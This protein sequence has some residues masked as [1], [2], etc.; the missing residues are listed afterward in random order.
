[1]TAQTA[2]T[3]RDCV[4]PRFKHRHGTYL[5]YEQDHC[6][7]LPCAL[8]WSQAKARARDGGRYALTAGLVDKT[9]TDRRIQGLLAIGWRH[10]DISERLARHLGRRAYSDLILKHPGRSVFAAT[11]AAVAAVY[12]ELSMTLGPSQRNRNRA[13]KAGY[14]PPLSWDDDQLDDPA[15]A[16]HTPTTGARDYLPCGTEAAA[17]RHQRRGEPLDAACRAAAARARSSRRGRAA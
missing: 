4:C 15:A 3:R 14:L 5:A 7:C 16:P 12:D 11:A 17:R 2:R 13:R 10:S 6:R 8:A 9:G 1:M